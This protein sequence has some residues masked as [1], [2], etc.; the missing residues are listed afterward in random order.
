MET[1]I[2]IT[3]HNFHSNWTMMS[4]QHNAYRKRSKWIL[5]RCYGMNTVIGLLPYWHH[6]CHQC[7]RHPAYRGDR[8]RKRLETKI[9][10]LSLRLAVGLQKR[11][12]FSTRYLFICINNNYIIYKKS[13]TV[14]IVKFVVFIVNLF[15][16]P[17]VA[18]PKCESRQFGLGNKKWEPRCKLGFA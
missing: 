11:R 9:G 5:W 3:R 12:K 14:L 6:G 15:W 7:H 10:D 18:S 16:F 17:L 2:R 4:C 8:R 13:F 1:K